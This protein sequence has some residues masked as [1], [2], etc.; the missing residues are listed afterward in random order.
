[1][2]ILQVIPFVKTLRKE[3]LSYFSKE[4]VS[5][6]SIVSINLRKRVVQGL[7]IS[8]KDGSQMKGELKSSEFALR[9]IKKV[10][11][12][13]LF[14]HSFIRSSERV[15]RY[16]ATSTGS[17]I[18]ALTPARI[19][20]EI[21]KIPIIKNEGKNIR[22]SRG[23]KFVI[24]ESDD[25]RYSSYKALIREEFAKKRSVLFVCPTIEDTLRASSLLYKGIEE[26]TFVFH[27]KMTKKQILEEWK[28]C[29]TDPKPVLIII[30]GTFLGI[31][32][33]D[34]GSII[35][36]KES[37]HS[38]RLAREPYID[39][40]LCAEYYAEELG[41]RFFSGDL[42]LKAE[43]LW[44]YQN[45]ELYERTPLQFRSLSTS[46]QKVI[47]MKKVKNPKGEKFELFSRELDVLILKT[48]EEG[49]Q[50]FIYSVRKGLSPSVVCIDCNTIVSC[51]NC[52]KGLVLYGKDA[53]KEGNIL[54]C[55][56][57]GYQCSAGI[58]CKHCNSWRLQTLGIGTNLVSKE[59]E[60]LV[61]KDSIFVLDSE[62]AKTPKQARAIIDEFYKRP[63]SFLVGTDMAL[64]YLHEPIENAAVASIDSLFSIPEF[65]IRE[66]IMSTLLKIKTKTTENSIIQTRRA[67]DSIFEYIQ[68][69][70][71]AEFY[72]EEF[73]ERKELD[74]PPFSLII[75][76]TIAGPKAQVTKAMEDL[77]PYFNPY[78]FHTYQAFAEKIKNRFVMNGIIKLKHEEWINEALLKKLLAL[79]PQFRVIVGTDSLL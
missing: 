54:R 34:I 74:F 7:V 39:I 14:N 3:H 70:N 69:G 19:L 58:L 15:A 42:M 46:N 29:T 22:A 38:Y 47:D 41:A 51:P 72:R 52:S 6:G 44:R 65:Y 17:V 20:E 68:N 5:P 66:K 64:I 16:F 49:K 23:E 40:R 37:T 28:T 77:K 78:E 76:I 30:T 48:K 12:Q 50:M 57:C 55:H 9:K 60:R 2:Y 32:R 73:K 43:T 24:Q 11:K 31:P 61:P 36:E 56:S 21:D 59:L 79:P 27:S 35:V 75:K 13:T 10:H 4:K 67:D 25:E 53:T 26:H 62:S 18:H 1:M 8:S 63:G 33:N 71:I 45:H